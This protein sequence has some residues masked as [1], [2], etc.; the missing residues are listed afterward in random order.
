M[1]R[2]LR[3]RPSTVYGRDGS[4]G[5]AREG[6]TSVA[7][8]A[9]LRPAKKAVPTDADGKVRNR[10]S[11]RYASGAVMPAGSYTGGL[12]ALAPIAGFEEEDEE[13]AERAQDAPVAGPVPPVAGAAAAAVPAAP[14]A[15][16]A[17]GTHRGD[18]WD[19]LIG[20][21]RIDTDAFAKDTFDPRAFVTSQMQ[22]QP[23]SGLRAIQGSLTT[24]Q[25]TT[26][27]QLKAQVFRNYAEFITISKEIAT[28]E[29]DML[30]FKE[31]L[32]EWKQL[33]QQLQL[34]DPIAEL[35]GDV[36]LRSALRR[37][38]RNSSVDLEQIYKAQISALWENIEGS[39]K[40]VPYVPGRH[41]IAETSQ[42]LEM[43]AATYKPKQAVALFLL[44]DLL[45]IA[46]QRKRHYGSSRVHLVAERCFS[47]SEIVVV[48]LKDGRD[49]R[50]AIKIKHGKEVFVYRTEKNQD[51]RALLNAFRRVGEDLANKMKRE[52]KAKL[53][54]ARGAGDG[55]G[56]ALD[57]APGEL[58][59]DPDQTRSA[60]PSESDAQA[61]GAWLN[62][63]V[64]DLAVH[65]ALR[66]WEAAVEIVE[67]GKRRLANRAV[68]EG[69]LYLLVENFTACANEL[70][71]AISTELA[72]PH[73][74]KTTVVRDADLLLRLDKGR[75]A[76]DL[77]LRARTDLLR[78]RTR[79]IRYEGDVS[80]YISKL[81]LL[82]FT[83]IKN[84]GDWYMSA[85]KDYKMASG[86][87]KWASDQVRAYAEIFRRQV[88]GASLDPAVIGECVEI[89]MNCAQ[90]LND[91]GLGLGYLLE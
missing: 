47:L 69:P 16:T 76:R 60:E 41:L 30:E 9:L 40:F 26:Q 43:N 31:L 77:L 6:G 4:V 2:S 38:S 55:A 84:T 5:G 62:S 23:E 34:E 70:V 80:L 13:S 1:S 37:G 67:S 57:M 21:P 51:K 81:A 59:M 11:M 10:L 49:L 54:T 18:A 87:V 85:F 72:S 88:Y 28:L 48:D 61:L 68:S 52:Q 19:A 56:D 71:A 66:E 12:G 33:P 20:V 7:Q 64:D 45:L 8:H 82:Y 44:D 91:V 17:A 42:F 75:D 32:Q 39:Q 35:G 78:R 27:K 36:S 46:V 3:T 58:S 73:Q 25:D 24:V 89:T 90:I 79:Q 53:S 83:L 29:N 63:V 14:A 22:H 15:R 86:F 50:H 74:Q 65:I